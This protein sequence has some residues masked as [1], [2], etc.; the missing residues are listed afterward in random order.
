MIIIANTGGT[1]FYI[2]PGQSMA[3]SSAFPVGIVLTWDLAAT[4]QLNPGQVTSPLLVTL[5]VGATASAGPL[6]W[7]TTFNGFSTPTGG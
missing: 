4:A 1:T 7:T 5:S 2:I 6:S 3:T